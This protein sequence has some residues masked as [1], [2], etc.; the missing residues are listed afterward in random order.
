MQ[1][2]QVSTAVPSDDRLSPATRAFLRQGGF[3]HVIEGE[4]VASVSGET[5]AVYE[6]ACSTSA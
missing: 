5:F 2:T 3:G 1:A 4:V 6:R